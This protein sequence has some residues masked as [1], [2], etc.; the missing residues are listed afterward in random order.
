M[1]FFRNFDQFR[2]SECGETLMETENKDRLLLFEGDKLS[3]T[4][5]RLCYELIENHVDFR[6]TVILG[7]QPR[8]IFLARRIH[9]LL[10]KLVPG[11]EI[12]LGSLDV[13]FY[14]DDFRRQSGPLLANATR[15]DFPVEG[16]KVLL[17][18]D[19][20]Y[21]GRTVRAALD[22]MLAFGRPDRVELL[23]LVDRKRKR[24]FPVE[25]EYTGI[26]VDTL[27]SERVVVSLA[28]SGGED[29]I[30]IESQIKQ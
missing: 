15:I 30:Y 29:I 14:R 4:L 21:T 5:K 25:S 9:E 20:L 24:E 16:K 23:V 26:S 7:I 27:D 2:F 12:C 1:I 3:I 11:E 17:V 28:E 13:T 19:V 6:D 10:T 8:G 22:A 18:D